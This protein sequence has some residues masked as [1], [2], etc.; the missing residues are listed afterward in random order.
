[1]TT[2]VDREPVHLFNDIRPLR[3]KIDHIPLQKFK[4]GRP[5][6]GAVIQRTEIP[7]LQL[8]REKMSVQF[9]VR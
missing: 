5:H 9:P 7:N 8:H 6:V 2:Q 4:A 3:I 1:M